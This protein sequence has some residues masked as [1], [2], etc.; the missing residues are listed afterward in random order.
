[1]NFKENVIISHKVANN[2]DDVNVNFINGL[3][4]LYLNIV[5]WRNKIDKLQ[6]LI[7]SFKCILDVIVL[8]EVRISENELKFYN[9]TNYKT[10]CSCR[11]SNT[12]ESGGG[13]AI[14]IR[15]GIK[16]IVL[17]NK[18]N[19]YDNI[20]LINLPHYKLNVGAVYRPPDERNPTEFLELL[21]EMLTNS[22][23]IICGD[24]N[25]NLLGKKTIVYDYKDLLSTSGYFLIN[26]IDYNHATRISKD[27]KSKTIIDHF[28]TNIY[29]LESECTLIDNDISDHRIIV[30]S[31]N[32][33]N[34]KPIPEKI[35][36]IVDYNN[37]Q[38]NLF[39][40]PIV[41]NNSNDVN[42]VYDNFINDLHLRIDQFTVNKI[43]N[44]TS[45]KFIKSW[46]SHEI[47]LQIAI[48]NKYYAATKKF[49]NS[50]IHKNLYKNQLNIVTR[51]KRDAKAE[52]F[53]KKCSNV[54][55]MSQLW[56]NVNEILYNKPSNK[57]EKEKIHKIIRENDGSV[58]TDPKSIANH[59]NEYFCTVG[60]KLAKKI[61]FTQ[62]LKTLKLNE[63]STFY[64]YKSNVNEIKQIIKNL[65]IKSTPGYDNITTKVIQVCVNELALPL[66]IIF[67]KIIKYG[68]Y[69]ESLKIAKVIP[70]FKS[71]TR[72]NPSNFRPISILSIIAKIFDKVFDDRIMKFMEHNNIIS[73]NQFAFI[74]NSSTEATVSNVVNT[75]QLHLDECQNSKAG[76]L[77]ID[78]SKAFDTVKI[79]YL[80]DKL[81]KMGIRGKYLKLIISYLSSRKQTVL[82]EDCYSD[83]KG[84]NF[85]IQ[86]GGTTSPKFF[87]LYL[88]DLCNLKLRGKLV[89]YADDICLIYENNDESSIVQDIQYDL[90][91]LFQWFNANYL[92]MN[93]EKTK[94]MIVTRMNDQ[95]MYLNPKIQNIY[96]E[97]VYQ[98]KYLG[99]VIDSKLKFNNQI[100]NVKSKIA[101]VIGILWRTKN[102]M[103]PVVKNHVY[104]AFVHSHLNYLVGIWGNAY[105]K[106]LNKLKVM[107]NKVIKI[108]YNYPLRKH[109][110]ELYN[111]TKKFNLNSMNFVAL[112]TLIYRVVNNL[113]KN[114]FELIFNR[115]FH[116][117]NT[118]QAINLHIDFRRTNMGK[119]SILTKGVNYYN[120]LPK[121][122]KQS[123]SLFIFKKKLKE[124]V[125]GNLNKFM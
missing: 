68:Q 43:I 108:M 49:P 87:I 57:K 79:N 111:E 116:R 46:M 3:N 42:L 110:V 24:L 100:H 73:P 85:G 76:M 56:S 21:E 55:Q 103:P 89:I 77:F 32:N 90:D 9:I 20:L 75:L 47:L 112:C 80:I 96:I 70:I 97:K 45:T 52:Y 71:G 95:N 104:N 61:Q 40:Y 25:I 66:T 78:L 60:E 88:N 30:L 5:T 38:S 81:Q 114:D 107:Q 41:L 50:D 91:L 115:E 125:S 27:T 6:I 36:K 69:P 101:P 39:K 92:T 74:K 29:N 53:S 58:I 83:I 16:P 1:M 7:N 121:N 65:K 98:Y 62:Q 113:I 84:L 37:L 19:N 11:V 122:I 64:F 99:L 117:H 26:K 23:T 8:T 102:I 124:F 10:F 14:L 94:Y 72:T 28:I 2:I 86:Q 67:N 18:G 13:V 109:T 34:I 48:K 4:F 63:N 17:L 59:F 119:M 54:T 123:K 120:E 93:V 35:I 22:E 44:V 31:C 82:I 33:N 118:R 15:D 106:Y 51:L 105:E 12:K